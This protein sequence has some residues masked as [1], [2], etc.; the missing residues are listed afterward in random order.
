MGQR[1]NG[2]HA[3][4]TLPIWEQKHRIQQQQGQVVFAEL[5]L[6]SHTNEHILNIKE[7]YQRHEKLGKLLNDYRLAISSANN[8]SLLNKAFQLGEITMLEYFLENSIYQNVIQHFLKTEYNYQVE[9]AK[10]LQY[11]F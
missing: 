4:M 11:K 10:L 9:K 3:S 1:F 5:N 2:I 6:Q 7:K 8:S